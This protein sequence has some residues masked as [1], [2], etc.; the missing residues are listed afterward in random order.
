MDRIEITGL[1][2]FGY[3]GVLDEE[4]RRGQIFSV[5]LTIEHDLSAAATSDDLGDTLD[6][7]ALSSRLAEAVANTRFALLEALAAHLAELVLTGSNASAVEVRVAKPDVDLPVDVG[8]VA[9]VVRRDG[10]R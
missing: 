8:E 9:V 2:A 1:R 6:Y 4:Q 3:H 7:A 10:A 5:D